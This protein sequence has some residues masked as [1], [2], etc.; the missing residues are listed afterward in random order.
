MRLN[1]QKCAFEVTSG[2]LL[3]YVVSQRGIE[4]DPSKIKAL[5]EMPQPQIEKEVRGRALYAEVREKHKGDPKLEKWR[6]AVEEG[7][8]SRFVVGIDGGLKF[9]GRWCIPD[10]EDLKRKIL[11]EAHSTPY[12]VHPGGDKVKGEHKIPHGKV[13]SL[14]VPEW[15]WEII[16]MDFIVGLPRTQKGNNMIWL[17]VDRLTKTTHFIPM[18]DTWSKAEL[19]KAY[20]KNIVKLHGIPKD[21][22]SDRDSRFISKFWQELQ[23]CMGTALKMSSAF[24]PAI[25]GQTE[26]TI[27][28]LED[29]LRA[30][31][32]EFGGSW[33]ER[34]PVCWDDVTDA[35]TLGPEL[36]QQMMVGQ[37]HVIRQK[38]RAA[39]DRQKSYAD[40]KRSEIQFAIGDKVLLKVSPMKGVMWF[41]KRGKLSQKYMTLWDF[42][43]AETVEMDENLSY[44]E[45]AKEILDRK[46]ATWE[47]EAEMKEKYP[48]LFA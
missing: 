32:L 46:E 15:K 11:T 34:S 10:D 30:C 40:L 28:T 41:G 48:H 5:I 13:Q 24:H 47:V 25:D 3:G 22:V 1:P 44:E 9:D 45:V 38:M 19:A 8:P 23:E 12:S 31:V 26:R 20:V 17:I 4:I 37:V 27:Q 33:E 18:K 6:A 16:S 35:V 42:R 2:K 43:Q 7:V 21:I 29:M 36:I 14:D 39:Q